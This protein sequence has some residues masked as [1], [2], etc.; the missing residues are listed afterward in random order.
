MLITSS[1]E[2]R[3]VVS[4][5]IRYP[6]GMHR[7]L[8]MQIFEWNRVTEVEA[9]G[10]PFDEILD[11]AL[12]MAEEFPTQRGY[13]ADVLDKTKYMLMVIVTELYQER[14]NVSNARL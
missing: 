11:A 9:A 4:K 3:K 2:D 8:A 14:M 13:E 1:L 10:Y 6:D 5:L 12:I 7:I